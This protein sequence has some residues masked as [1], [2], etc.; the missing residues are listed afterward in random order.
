VVPSLRA[1]ASPRASAAAR[2]AIRPDLAAIEADRSSGESTIS[3]SQV[4]GEVERAGSLVVSVPPRP[5]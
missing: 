3:L 2:A 5:R 4:I 1:G